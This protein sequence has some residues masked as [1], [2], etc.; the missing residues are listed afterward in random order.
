MDVA[1]VTDS[2]ADL[3]VEVGAAVAGIVPLTVTVADRPA[4]ARASLDLAEFYDALRA[5]APVTTS[6]PT[7]SAFLEVWR[8]AVE[9]GARSI[10][11]VHVAS[12]LSGTVDRARS[13]ASDCPVPVEVVDSGQVSGGLALQVLAAADVARAGG[14]A[15]AVR[16]AA[17]AIRR[18]TT[19]L[20]AVA[21]IAHLRRG[22]RLVADRGRDVDVPLRSHP[23]LAIADGDIVPIGR[24]RTWRRAL[25]RLASSVAAAGR[26]GEEWDVVVGH[27][28]EPERAAAL[29]AAVR[30]H[31]AVGSATTVQFGPV[32]GAHVGP[33]AVGVAAAP[34]TR[35]AASTPA[36]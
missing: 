22:G 7:G 17:A 1:V 28:A 13:V 16:E 2:T 6:Q 36:A 32:V 29:L 24:A 8:A 5:G 14:D 15:A 27:A 4:V 9:Q 3:D 33:G 21:D 20:V 23:V 26:P 25:A 12:G 18:T 11:S 10:V 34:A 35:A 31:V 30:E 19:S